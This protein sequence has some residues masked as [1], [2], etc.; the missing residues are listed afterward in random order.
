MFL[1]VSFFFRVVYNVICWLIEI[2]RKNECKNYEIKEY[3]YCLERVNKNYVIFFSIIL[4]LFLFF[5]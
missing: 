2:C 4:R 5:I 1:V 3:L